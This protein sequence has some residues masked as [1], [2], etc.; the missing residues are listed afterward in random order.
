MFFSI[1][2]SKYRNL[3]KSEIN[4]LKE[5]QNFSSDWQQIYVK[6]NFSPSFIRRTDFYGTIYIDG[7]D[8]ESKDFR[9]L[10]Y[11]VGIINSVIHT[12][13]IGF[14]ASL[15]NVKFLSNYSVKEDC[16]LCNISELTANKNGTFGLGTSRINPG[17]AL[18]VEVANENG[19]RKIMPFPGILTMDAYLWSKYRDEQKLMQRFEDMTRALCLSETELAVIGAHSV[20]INVGII[21]NSRIGNYCIIDG[22]NALENIYV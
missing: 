20:I 6:D 15:R 1:D 22:A 21:R 3:N 17:N 11:S 4:A 18:W 5:N 19:G 10:P 8:T 9:N 2:K 7:F 13:H 14:N 16:I 12:S